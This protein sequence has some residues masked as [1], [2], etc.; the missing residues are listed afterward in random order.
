M[1]AVDALFRDSFGEAKAV[2]EPV[3]HPLRQEVR[4]KGLGR[5]GRRSDRKRLKNA[6]EHDLRLSF[7]H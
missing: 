5:L 4:W 7:S 6:W 3:D 2:V 1:A